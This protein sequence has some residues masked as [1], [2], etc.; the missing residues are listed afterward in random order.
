MLGVIGNLFIL[1]SLAFS[2]RGM[3]LSL[4]ARDIKNMQI[5]STCLVVA[6][7]LALIYGFISSDFLL[8]NVFINSSSISPL[9]YKIAAS[10]SSHE[11]SMLLFISFLSLISL[12][13]YFAV[14]DSKI[15][16]KVYFLQQI[17]ISSLLLTLWITA[18]PFKL[19]SFNPHEGIGLNPL[20][21]D[22]ALAYHPPILY[23]GYAFSFIPFCYCVFIYKDQENSINHFYSILKFSRLALMFLTLG[24]ALGSWWAYRELGWGGFWFFDPVENISLLPWLCGIAFHHSLLSSIKQNA[25]KKWTVFFGAF[26]FPLPLIGMFLVRSNLLVSVHSFAL[27]TTKALALGFIAT[28]TFIVSIYSY[29]SYTD[30]IN[31]EKTKGLFSKETGFVI[32]NIFW[33]LAIISVLISIMLPILVRAFFDF[34]I[35]L[36]ADY[37]KITLLPILIFINIVTSIYAYTNKNKGYH[38]FTI[39]LSFFVALALIYYFHINLLFSSAAILVAVFLIITTVLDFLKKSHF[40]KNTLRFGQVA[41]LLGHFSYGLFTLSIAL[42]ASLE[43]EAD[44]IGTKNTS[45]Q[46]G[47]FEITLQNIKYSHGP[48]YLRQIAD[49][50]ILDTKSGSIIKLAPENRWYAIE[51]KMTAESSIYSFINY[52]LYAVLNRITEGDKAHIKIYYRP[53][54]SFIW[55]A[56]TT[57]ALS[58]FIS[59]FAVKKRY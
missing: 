27:D 30:N 28:I 18:N 47:D 42:N 3:F 23:L 49:L 16:N 51:N 21:Q 48:N 25:L 13:S 34:E 19:S 43:G 24:I 39:G 2:A 45:V 57:L 53:Y 58:F 56:S 20:L 38:F 6:S 41:M 8:Q 26:I 5:Y 14:N 33:L 7:M 1:C 10:W 9:I 31:Q 12:Y 40:F 37:F 29:L 36:E 4:N 15:K 55:L 50:K 35:A 52:D 32:G 54:I 17:I 44:L 46:M 22:I 59:L 11:G